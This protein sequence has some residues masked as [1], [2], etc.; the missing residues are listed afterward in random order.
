VQVDTEDGV[1]SEVHLE[2]RV[3]NQR[4]VVT[5][6]GTAVVLLPSREHGAVVLPSP[7]ADSVA[8]MLEYEIERLRE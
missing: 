1:R 4:G 7:P 8:A 6:P 2:I 5:S 3:T